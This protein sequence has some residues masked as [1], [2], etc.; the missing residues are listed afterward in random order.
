MAHYGSKLLRVIFTYPPDHLY[1]KPW[2]TSLSSLIRAYHL[3]RI[4]DEMF[5]VAQEP[6]VTPMFVVAMIFYPRGKE[7]EPVFAF[8]RRLFNDGN[9]YAKNLALRIASQVVYSEDLRGNYIEFVEEMLLELWSGGQ[10]TYRYPMKET[11]DSDVTWMEIP[12]GFLH[13]PVIFE[14]RTKIGGTLEFIERILQLPW[15]GNPDSRMV[16]IL[17]S[18]KDAMLMACITMHI[19]IT[20][21]LETLRRW[22]GSDQS[23]VQDALV[24]LLSVARTFDPATTDGFLDSLLDVT[25]NSDTE[26]S[27]RITRLIRVVC[28]TES[29]TS[30]AGCSQAVSSLGRLVQPDSHL[31][32]TKMTEVLRASATEEFG[33]WDDIVRSLSGSIAS[34]DLL[35]EIARAMLSVARD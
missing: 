6:I 16:S 3:P 5:M 12:V 19:G 14:C 21:I 27:R 31:W 26:E 35:R 11:A 30:L 23:A 15:I 33:D 1:R 7:P 28:E 10:A 29:G 2:R 34:F 18:L 17:D 32:R 22:V 4:L 13:A 25:P 9:L 8:C 20:P 24:D